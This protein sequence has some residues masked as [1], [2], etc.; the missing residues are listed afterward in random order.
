M[1]WAAG[2]G[3]HT[4][5]TVAAFAVT[6]DCR[7]FARLARRL[8]FVHTSLPQRAAWRRMGQPLH[9]AFPACHSTMVTPPCCSHMPPELLDGGRLSSG[10]ADVFSLGTLCWEASMRLQ[11][12]LCTRGSARFEGG[13]GPGCQ[14]LAPTTCRTLPFHAVQM[15]CS[16]HAWEGLRLPQIIHRKAS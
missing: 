7:A 8:I 12:Q 5:F 14:P 11:W 1:I 13:F 15:Y 10:A 2:S 16:A 3:R 4:P 9:D 6:T